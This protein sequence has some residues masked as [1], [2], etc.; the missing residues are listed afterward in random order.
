MAY[1]DFNGM[2]ANQKAMWAQ[3]FGGAAR[4]DG[5][6]P[7][8]GQAKP[9]LD[10]G[11]EASATGFWQDALKQ[12]VEGY[13]NSL[14]PAFRQEVGTMLGN[15]N[16]IGA[17]RSGASATEMQNIMGAYGSQ[18]GNYAKMASEHGADLGFQTVG[19]EREYRD[20]AAERKAQR[21][22][23][24]LGGIGSLLG[25]GIGMFVPGAK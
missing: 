13:G 7:N 21:K 25:A 22:S 20:R 2:M 9:K 12:G 3:S 23:S 6:Q 5:K 4:R 8:Q 18:I 14:M 17:L 10:R 15:L 11:S 1:P 16:S 19:M 24:M